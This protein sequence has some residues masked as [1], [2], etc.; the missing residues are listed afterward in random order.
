M[1]SLEVYKV[2]RVTSIAKRS[3]PSMSESW[4]LRL[5]DIRSC[6]EVSRVAKRWGKECNRDHRFVDAIDLFVSNR[7]SIWTGAVSGEST[8]SVCRRHGR[9]LRACRKCAGMSMNAEA[10]RHLIE[11]SILCC[12]GSSGHGTV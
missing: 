12:L 8:T 9:F 2:A 10:S 6:A 4:F 5:T 11:V 3:I 1:A 7:N